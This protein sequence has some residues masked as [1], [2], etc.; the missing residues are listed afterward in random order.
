MTKI[1]NT[2]LKGLLCVSMLVPVGQ[3][4]AQ[5]E[6]IEPIAY[7]DMDKWLVREV[8][9]S[10]VIGGATK[11]L[12]E[13]ASGD[14][15]F[16]NTPYKNQVSPWATSTVMAKVSG[17]VKASVTVFPEKR[18][19]GYC[20]RLETRMENCKVLGLINI[21]VLA[22]GTIFLGEM[23]EPIRDT[24]NPQSKLMTGIPFTKR[25]K[26]LMYD[27]KVETGGKRIRATGFSRITDLPGKDNAETSML[28]QH[29]WEDAS[30][31]IYARRV[32]TA[33]E[34]YDH[35]VNTWQNK[36]R[37]NVNYGDISSQAFYQPYMGL[38]NGENCHYTKNSKGQV[39]PIREVGWGFPNEE[40]THIVLRISSSHGGAYVGTPNSKFWVD[41]IALVY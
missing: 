29:R 21:T 6:K 31:N 22:S 9:E 41:N 12:F 39:V 7:G 30:G 23:E 10:Y 36:H 24:K 35:S 16:N 38:I 3:L 32:G 11:Y 40:I 37:L 19:N 18:D 33:W 26:A 34:R 8:E 15:L 17:V 14:T 1:V 20:A 28:L 2:L 25:P 13:I 27:Y 4:C 5:N